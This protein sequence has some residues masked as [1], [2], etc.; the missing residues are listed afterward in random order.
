MI[1]YTFSQLVDITQVRQLLESHHRLSRIAY[2]IVDPDG[3]ILVAVG[4]QEVCERFHRV[5]PI[6][7][8]RCRDSNA[9]IH[10]H[11]LACKGDYLESQCKNGLM[12][13]AL[14]VIISGKHVASFYAGQFFYDDRPD[15]AFFRNQAR[16]L[17]F[18]VDD[19]LASLELVPVFSRGYVRDNM[20]FLRDMVNVL[21][22]TGFNNLRLAREMEERKFVEQ[23][24]ELLGF[25]L[26]NVH[27]AAFLMDLS[28]RFH[29]V[30]QE[31]CR[32][33]GYT[34]DELLG[35]AIPDIDPDYQEESL[36]HVFERLLEQGT[37]TFET[38]HQAKDGRIFPVEIT[39]TVLEHHG[40]RYNLA[41]VR[42]ITERK[43]AQT[44]LEDERLLLKTLI[45]TLPDPVW[46]KDTNGFYITCNAAF[47]LL[48]NETPSGIAGRTDND[49]VDDELA[50]FFQQKDRE[51]I[52]AG[53]PRTNEEW[54]TYAS[55]GHRALWETTKTPVYGAKGQVVGALGV[56]RD[57]TE[58]KRMEESL[59]ARE[60]EFR[61]LAENAP[62]VIVRYDLK[63]R[64]IYVNPAFERV[65][66]LSSQEVLGKTPIELSTELAPQAVNFTQHLKKVLETGVATQIDLGVAKDGIDSSWF[67]R[68]IPE[69][70]SNGEMVS[71]LTI[72]TDI[73]ERKRL[74][75]AL[76]ESEQQFRTLA[77]NSPDTIVRY[78]RQCRRVYVNPRMVKAF[79]VDSDLMLNKRLVESY[80]KGWMGIGEFEEKLGRVLESGDPDEMEMAVPHFSGELRIHHI[81]LAAERD[82]AGKVM[83]VLAIGR[84]ITERKK[85]EREL[86]DARS[87]LAAVFTTIPDLVWLKDQHG[88][89][90]ACNPAFEKYFG[91]PETEIIG[92]T[93]HDFVAAELADFFIRKDREAMAAGRV[94]INE[95][96]ITYADDGRQGILETR[97]VPVY[98]ADGTISGVLGVAR[99]IT[100]RKRAEELLTASEQRFREI[101]D[102]SLDCL[103][104]L[105]VTEDGRFRNLEINPVFERSTG[106]TCAELIGKY[107]DETVSEETGAAV[108]AKYRRCVAA[109]AVIEEEVELDL[110]SGHLFFYSTLVP[111]Q[112]ESGRIHRIVGI[113]R[114][115]TKRKQAEQQLQKALDFSEG[116]INAIPDL[117]FEL[118]R[119]GRYLN[120][121]TQKPELLAA[122][123][124]ILL[125]KTVHDV[126]S[127]ESAA[128]VI[129]SIRE[130]DEK[131]L[132]FGKTLKIDL[133]QG[134]CWFELSVSRKPG[135]VA[136][137]VR[138]IVLSRDITERKRMEEAL[139]ARER[140]FRTLAEN[141]PDVIVR[142]DRECRRLY[143]NPAFEKVNRLSPQEV[144]GK[145]PIELSTELAPQ[146][147]NFTQHLEE[148]LETGVAAQI[149]LS[150]AKD[151]IDSSWLVRVI[152]EFDF[153]GEVVSALTIWTD[154]TERKRLESA[155]RESEQQFRT[156][157]ENSP[158]IIIRYDRECRRIFVNPAYV[159]ETGIAAELAQNATPGMLWGDV[160]MPAHDYRRR[161]EE[162]ME[163]G[164]PSEIVL[165]LQLLGTGHITSHAFHVVAE[166]NPAGEIIGCLAIGHNITALKEAELRL[167]KL[168][169][170]VPGFLYTYRLRPDGT[171]CLPYASPQ[172]KDIYGFPPETATEDASE[173][174]TRIHPD[175]VSRVRD[176][177]AESARTLSLWHG[178]YR[179]RN[180]EKGDIWVEGRSMPEAQPDGGIVWFGFVHDIT[181]RKRIEESLRAKREQLTAM[182]VELSLAEERERRRIA[183]ELHDH[184]GQTL[185]LSRIKLGSLA[186]V[187]ESGSDEETYDEVQAL[188]EQTI[189][190][191]RSLTQQ[192]NPPLLAGVG[193]EAA[194]EWLSKRMEADYSLL[195]DFVDDRLAKPLSEDLRAVV[196]Q[197][198]R[199]LL[200]NVAKH[201]GTSE[202]RLTIG[203]EADMLLLTVED[204]GRGFVC[205]SNLGTNMS[206]ESSF[207]LFNIQQRIKL[208]GG[209][210]VIES[211]PGR[212]TCATIRVPLEEL[213]ANPPRL[214]LIT[215]GTF[216]PPP[217]IKGD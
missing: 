69:F 70:D 23:R 188:L 213:T 173:T 47:G 177:I 89:Y 65:N 45:Q 109:R 79:G 7:N 22:E 161:L 119:E 129:D 24:L 14:P 41:L 11:L 58:R 55:D 56:A 172:I 166:R 17:G 130:A 127:P 118:D 113:T 149:D 81:R 147:I 85:T 178:E 181:E 140:E 141:A 103:Y 13:A 84:D 102:N 192:L 185:L 139:V 39:S 193:L 151:G 42:D 74:E 6:S 190:D 16:E 27:E 34:G 159:R 95:E 77:E 88:I 198:A 160:S 54:L 9:Y 148:V 162:V 163:S 175:D 106:M 2:G 136:A 202:A 104:L 90:L 123:K 71:A 214:L 117:L 137:D 201:A 29:Y 184:I 155:L 40:A 122:Q 131:G 120:V 156:L 62:D 25:A 199:E 97:K 154:I 196:Y 125:E 12:D 86:R 5:N 203:R 31:A 107:V 157:A 143:V 66:R 48:Y 138:F 21:A 10:D 200:I 152:P 30:N 53:G 63:C 108:V 98:A 209:E 150:V 121:W 57:I 101:F 4:W 180:P 64:R 158:N 144:L 61:T 3:N 114:D 52:A 211:A 145:T 206:L 134:P 187:F 43:A 170:G 171:A 112:D 49:Y 46:L 83:G 73:T 186:D 82:A 68:V 164:A 197:S 142:Y 76:R 51:S 33:L 28:G 179:I 36:P 1:D 93:D 212:G 44:M 19:Y 207:G 153:N 8:A 216:N 128:V 100:E 126:L 99:D 183:S 78:D 92:K 20:L 110:P 116:V 111:V 115:I 176:S 205:T 50:A 72:W 208:L 189:R 94:C 124:E 168:A 35:M 135:G 146:A 15:T 18:D 87:R 32:S 194:L 26:D 167:S 191:V 217:L 215:G 165:E 60:R 105:E 169:A 38:R 96:E 67:V 195:V 132:S 75:S 204:Q 182:T 133:P 37:H 174:L 210:V 59:V 80:P 91:A